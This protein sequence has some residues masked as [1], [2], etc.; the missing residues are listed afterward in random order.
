MSLQALT[1]ISEAFALVLESNFPVARPVASRRRLLH[2]DHREKARDGSIAPLHVAA[3][4]C[5][6]QARLKPLEADI[7]SNRVLRR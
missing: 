7:A 1:S 4:S 3:I 5:H 6:A 2:Y